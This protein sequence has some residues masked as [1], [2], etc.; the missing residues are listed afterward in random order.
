MS[1]HQHSSS[2]RRAGFALAAIAG[3]SVL[4][5]FPAAA[6]QAGT[7]GISGSPPCAPYTKDTSAKGFK[8]EMQ[9]E[10]RE[11]DRRIHENIKRG[12][13]ADQELKCISLIVGDLQKNGEKTATLT[14]V[15]P[16]GQACKTARELKL[17]SG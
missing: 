3:A 15:P 12:A 1:L 4:A 9:C 8:A 11:S 6:Q 13:T 5:A 10:I 2:F 16:K 17:I 7:V 14:A